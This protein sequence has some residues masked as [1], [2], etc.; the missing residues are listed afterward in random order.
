MARR[1]LRDRTATSKTRSSDPGPPGFTPWLKNVNPEMHWDWPW[2][3]HVRSLLREVSAGNLRRL[4]II[5]PPQHGKALAHDTPMLTPSGWVTHGELAIGDEVYGS[6]GEP[7]RVVWTSPEADATYEVE[8][9]DG[10]VICCHP[11][12]EWVVYDAGSGGRPRVTLETHVMAGRGAWI[13]EPGR[14]GSRCRYSVDWVPVVGREAGLPIEPYTLGAWLGDGSSDRPRLAFAPA[15][16]AVA[17]EVA[18]HYP[19]RA[20][21]VQRQTGVGYADFGGGLPGL[22]RTHGLVGNKHIPD[23]YLTA[24]FG[25]RSRLLAGLMDTDGYIHHK[26]RRACFSTCN[27]TLADDVAVLVRTFGMRATIAEFDPVLS[28]SGIQG[29]RKVYQV[30]FSPTVGIPCQLD[31]KRTGGFDVAYRRR[32]I[33]DIRRCYPKTAKCITVSNDD[34]LYLAGRGLAL[35]H[36]TSQ[37]FRYLL[38][39]MLKAPGTR[40]GFGAYNQKYANRVSRQARKIARRLGLEFGEADAVDEWELANGS[41]FV[42]RGTGAGV[43]GFPF[44]IFC[45]DDAFKNRAEADSETTQENAYEWYMDDVTPR[46]QEDGALV[47]INVRW[48]PNDLIGRI[49]QSPEAHLWTWVRLPAVAETQ[50]ERD[51]VARRTFQPLGQPDP[52]GRRPGEPLCP[53]RFS[54]KKLEEKRLTEGEQGFGSIYQGNPVPRGGTMF[55]RN[56]YELVP[57]VP[58]TGHVRRFRYWDLAD[59]RK[60]RACFTSGVLMA[61]VGFGEARRFYVENVVRGRWHPAERNATIAQTARSDAELPGFERA[62]FEQPTHDPELSA[63]RAIMAAC[64]GLPVY[65]HNV[66][67]SGS[68]ELRAEP[69]AA[70]SKARLV[71]LVAGPWNSVYL[72]ELEA[73]PSG[74]YKDQVDSTTGCYNKLAAVEDSTPEVFQQP[75]QGPQDWSW[76]KDRGIWGIGQ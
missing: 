74:T 9:S 5:A 60:D 67:G 3:V 65:P 43:A 46:I 54:L 41:S 24:S 62:F 15:D 18:R 22:L 35:T 42:A 75:T 59:S 45:I 20:E 49:Q 32:G 13:G 37:F 11:R 12:H 57:F 8:F 53:E 19:T 28:S 71:F 14:R 48:G 1:S 70:A 72:T 50:E 21:W 52:L 69:F 39:R 36:N 76:A 2:L 66:S 25:Q 56:W 44:D 17:D 31:R 27:K 26:T 61:S 33:V 34:G 51:A 6:D 47:L 10:E 63:T 4:G 64:A 40:A 55:D 68:K 38:W 30:T 58:A 16:R 73:F 7:T 23:A 29:R